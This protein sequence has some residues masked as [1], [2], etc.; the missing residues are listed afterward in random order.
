MYSAEEQ[1]LIREDIF[2]WL[3]ERVGRV[4]SRGVVEFLEHRAGQLV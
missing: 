3:D 1:A 4:T 2:R